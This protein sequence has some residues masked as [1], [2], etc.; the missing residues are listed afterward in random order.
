MQAVVDFV[1]RVNAALIN[2]LLALIFTAAL[3]LFLWGGFLFIARAGDLNAREA[4]KR[5]MLWGIIG[6][7]V[8]A[9]VFTI[10]RI[11]LWTF[12]VSGTDLPNGLP[13]SI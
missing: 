1:A 9:S 12:D 4:G 3:F 8:M 11:M 6:M 10:L 7:V 13:L 5:H 2:P